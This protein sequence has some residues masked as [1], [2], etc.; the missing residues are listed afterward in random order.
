MTSTSWEN[1]AARERTVVVSV[2]PSAVA[3]EEVEDN[4]EGEEVAEDPSVLRSD[5]LASDVADPVTGDVV[6]IATSVAIVLMTS[7]TT[8]WLGG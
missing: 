5:E 6:V 2:D 8:A 3:G 4:M 1:W 7:M